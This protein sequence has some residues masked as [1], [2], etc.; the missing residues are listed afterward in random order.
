[1][2]VAS[3]FRAFALLSSAFV[4]AALLSAPVEAR[5][6]R[7]T[8]AA[9]QL[10][11]AISSLG[12]VQ[13]FFIP[14]ITRRIKEAGLTDTIAFRQAYAGTL[15]KP[16]GVLL[17]VQDGIADIGFEPGVFHP[18]KL[19][20]DQVSFAT[21]FCT[22]DPA[23]TTKAA[24][25]LI[26]S[27]PEVKAQ[28]DR[29]NVVK[30]ASGSGDAFQFFTNFPFTK[31]EDL[32]GRKLATTGA[33]LQLYKGLGVT[34]VDSN[35]MEYYNSTK[36]GVYEGFIIM[37]S[38]AVPMKYPEA[39]PFVNVIDFGSNYTNFLIMNKAS[40]ARLP[41]PIQKI[42]QDVAQEWA[43]RADKASAEAGRNG[44]ESA[45]KAFPNATIRAVSEDERRRWAMAMPNIAKEWAAALDKQGLPGARVLN[46][47]M[48]ALR[49]QGVKCLREWD[50][51]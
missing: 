49:A 3:R 2:A 26:A 17:G 24:N 39:A 19:P 51:G 27:I 36:S 42:I 13:D 16:R 8:V 11:K 46:E 40:L 22:S 14:E 33:L 4:S 50:K 5:E 43:V 28:Y 15:L 25:A 31:I 37:G 23:T 1:M 32:K 34:A 18:D 45:R 35:M 6:Y 44:I 9:G 47:Y 12:L 10:P 21:P 30:L 7:L 38:A 48:T 41:E 20:L 29:F